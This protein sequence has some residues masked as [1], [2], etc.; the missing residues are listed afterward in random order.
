MH[1]SGNPKHDLEIPHSAYTSS[2]TSATEISPDMWF[3]QNE[4]FSSTTVALKI[5]MAKYLDKES[6][7][8]V[9]G[10]SLEANVA[11]KI[12]RSFPINTDFRFQLWVGVSRCIS[13][14]VATISEV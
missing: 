14:S 11:R 13:Y 10:N 9:G 3:T 4:V 7:E 1:P 8:I 12:Q 6:L 2:S 5:F